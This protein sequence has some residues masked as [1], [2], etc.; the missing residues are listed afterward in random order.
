MRAAICAKACLTRPTRQAPSS[1]VV[2]HSK[3]I[4]QLNGMRAGE[5]RA[6]MSRISHC[7]RELV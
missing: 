1:Q 3:N 5:R 7:S 2:I 4:P 6:V